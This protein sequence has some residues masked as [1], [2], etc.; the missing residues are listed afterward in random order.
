VSFHCEHVI[1]TQ[2][3]GETNLENLALACPACNFRKGTNLTGIDEA[4]GKVVKLFHPRQDRWA[5]HFALRGGR[6]E[7]LTETGRATA[8]LL[9]FNA[10]ER[11][12]ARDF[13][14]LTGG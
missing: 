7:P 13:E 14:R 8:R 1:A 12:G 11:V 9:D 4:T 5:E 3:G 10:A 2:H 6:I